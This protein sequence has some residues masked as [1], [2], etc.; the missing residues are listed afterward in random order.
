MILRLLL[1]AL[2]MGVLET[3]LLIRVTQATSFLTVFGL[4]L[5]AFV[6]G[7]SLLRGLTATTQARLAAGKTPAPEALTQSLITVVAALLLIFPGILSD[8]A[9]AFLMIPPVQRLLGRRFAKAIPPSMST[10]A[11]FGMN[12]GGNYTPPNEKSAAREP[13]SEPFRPHDPHQTDPRTVIIDAEIIDGTSKDR[14]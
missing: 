8:F 14:R 9:A 10:F 6:A 4:V 1:L 2:T 13:E 3:W 11:P 12:F 7:V 5:L